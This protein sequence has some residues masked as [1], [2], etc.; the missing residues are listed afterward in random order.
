[1]DSAATAAVFPPKGDPVPAAT[2]LTFLQTA[3]LK[4]TA[5]RGPGLISEMRADLATNPFVRESLPG[6]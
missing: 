3:A 4:A 5:T 6:F 1:M 2:G